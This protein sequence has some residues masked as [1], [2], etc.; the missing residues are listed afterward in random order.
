MWDCRRLHS[1]PLSFTP[2]L[3]HTAYGSISLDPAVSS[4][5]E[6]DAKAAILLVGLV[7]YAQRLPTNAWDPVAELYR[8][9]GRLMLSD[10]MSIAWRWQHHNDP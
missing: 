4:L 7:V 2:A 1:K 8:S 5:N 3:R 6:L 9:V 10:E